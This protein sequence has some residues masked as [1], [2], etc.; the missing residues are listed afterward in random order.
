MTEDNKNNKKD[1]LLKLLIDA[2]RDAQ[3][4]ASKGREVVKQ[5]QYAA[6]FASCNEEFI[7]CIPDD[8]FLPTNHRDNQIASRTRWRQNAGEVSMAFNSMQPLMFAT[9]STSIAS[10]AAISSVYIANLPPTSQHQAKEVFQRYEQLIEQANPI[11]ELKIELSRLKLAA[12]MA[13]RES[14]MS[15]VQQAYEAFNVPSVKEVLHQQSLFL[16]ERR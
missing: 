4:L 9:D 7:R 2:K 1:E 8:T 11:Q 13:G 3:D 12:S 10:R 15:L 14:V 6:D 5:G 16:C